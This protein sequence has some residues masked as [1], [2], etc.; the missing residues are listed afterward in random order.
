[1]CC[2]VSFSLS[3]QFFFP[4]FFISCLPFSSSAL[5]SD[6]SR[7]FTLTCVP[8]YGARGE[9][10]AVGWNCSQN[11]LSLDELPGGKLMHA[12]LLP[13]LFSEMLSGL[14]DAR[15]A[16]FPSQHWI[17]LK[18]E[19]KHSIDW[20]RHWLKYCHCIDL[21]PAVDLQHW[22]ELCVWAEVINVQCISGVWLTISLAFIPVVLI[23]GSVVDVMLSGPNPGVQERVY[24]PVQTHSLS[25]W[26]L[27][28]CCW[29]IV[30]GQRAGCYVC[31]FRPRDEQ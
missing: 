7:F 26:S 3:F 29:K 31:L 16:V 23:F 24:L 8:R 12:G 13:F 15:R 25:V 4:V 14:F 27:S 1:M 5:P 19:K 6:N 22:L 30:T 20:N 9:S 2:F 10:D 18:W 17:Y 28:H 21:S 11:M